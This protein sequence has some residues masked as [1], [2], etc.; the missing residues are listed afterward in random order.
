[1]K[2]RIREIEKILDS[3][4]Y[5]TYKLWLVGNLIFSLSGVPCLLALTIELI[6]YIDDPQDQDTIK[7]VFL[8]TIWLTW[9][10]WLGRQ[11]LRVKNAM[12]YMSLEGTKSG[13]KSMRWFSVYHL[14]TLVAFLWLCDGF[15]L[16]RENSYLYIGFCVGL[17]TIPTFLRLLGARKAINWLEKRKA[18]VVELE[19]RYGYHEDNSF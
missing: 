10:I 16:E 4:W 2:I 9:C 6:V 12:K 8:L 3:G 1:L 7:W 18:L 5:W 17:Y 15:R 11:C 13:F 19:S 14:V